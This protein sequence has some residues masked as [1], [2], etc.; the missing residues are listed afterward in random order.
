[1]AMRGPRLWHSGPAQGSKRPQRRVWLEQGAPSQACFTALPRQLT[2]SETMPLQMATLEQPQIRG[3]L[4]SSPQPLP[5]CL[6]WEGSVARRFGTP[7]AKGCRVAQQ[8]PPKLGLARCERPGRAKAS[9]CAHLHTGVCV[10]VHL[11]SCA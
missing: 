7:P 11:R 1:M 4:P 3:R 2:A 9:V 8:H 6:S 5:D 10:G